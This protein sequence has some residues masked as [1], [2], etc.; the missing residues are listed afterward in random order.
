MKSFSALVATLALPSLL[1][2]TEVQEGEMAGYLFGPAEKV[3]EE[4]DGGFSLYAAAWPLVGTYP[5]HKFQTGLCGTW[6]HPQWDE[7]QKPKEKCYTDIEGGLGWWRDTHFPTTTPKFIMGG[8]GPNFS[9]IANGPG[10][11]AGTWEKP[12][13]QYG[14]AQLSPW[15]LF[16]LDGLNLKQGTKG[17]LFGYGYLP[18]PLTNPK[19]TTA[20]KNV[21]TGNLCWTLYLNTA[22]FK[23]PATFFTPFFWTQATVDHP[24]WSG[25]LLDSRPARPNK[26]I[27]METQHVPAVLNGQHARVAPT[28]FPVGPDGTSTVLHRLTAYKKAALWDEVQKWFDGGAPADGAIKA[29]AS[30]VHKFREGG[31]SNWSIYPPGTKREEKVPLAWS[32]FATSFTPN[33]ITF[34]YKWNEQLTRTSD[35][36][37]TLPEYYQ[38]G[39][40]ARNKPQ[41][42]VIQPKE[43]PAVL[44][45]TQHRFFTPPEKPQEPRTTPDDAESCWKNPGPKAG[46]FKA[47]LGDGSVVT[48]YWYRFADQP[49][50]LNAD[51]TEAERELV[52]A[53]VEKLHR[54]WT[55]DRNYLTPPD[56]GTLASIDP[57]L[58][59]TPPPGLEI[60]YVPIATRQELEK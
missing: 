17:E 27:Q 28:R 52:Q 36:L 8:V 14:V 59:L 54:T 1:L 60:G 56:L 24:E 48:Y 44:G 26:A 10:Y 11:G 18:L 41:W 49:A 9:F 34:G 2:S 40:N 57:A 45:L 38:L 21:P 6:M 33:P 53:R 43:V 30:A 22:N 46:P 55:K 35:G 50:M 29:E 37:V 20:G 3:P 7:A 32:S 13:G 51:L 31:G 5:G 12:R 25:L 19:A 23:G 47:K 15:L 42:A 4:F 39:T 58:I 16:P